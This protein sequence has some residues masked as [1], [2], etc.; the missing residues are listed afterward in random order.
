MRVM[1]REIAELKNSKL[2]EHR[3]KGILRERSGR[4]KRF[5]G[6]G[7]EEGDCG[8]NIRRNK[9]GT[10]VVL[11]VLAGIVAAVL[12]TMIRDKKAGKSIQCGG[13]CTACKGHCQAQAAQKE[14]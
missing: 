3:Q 7:D 1:R 9:M 6:E 14:K 13:N 11:V 10:F 4:K 8:T 12:R 5:E 2:P